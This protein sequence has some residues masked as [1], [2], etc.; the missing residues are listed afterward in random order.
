[1]ERGA[2]SGD[3]ENGEQ[4]LRSEFYK[5]RHCTKNRNL[6]GYFF[7]NSIFGENWDLLPWMQKILQ[8]SSM[9]DTQ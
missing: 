2:G 9:E 5:Y 8:S 6:D 3:F 4:E 1:M 7:F